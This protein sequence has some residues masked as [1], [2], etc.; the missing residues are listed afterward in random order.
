MTDYMKKGAEF[1]PRP[2]TDNG[3]LIDTWQKALNG[4]ASAQFMMG[5][6]YEHGLSVTKSHERCVR[7]YQISRDNGNRKALLALSDIDW[8]IGTCWFEQVMELLT[9]RAKKGD[10]TAMY[11]L[12]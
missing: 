3:S 9:K 2:E 1:P 4:D 7:W 8:G 11:W 6:A 10:P 12:G 5:W